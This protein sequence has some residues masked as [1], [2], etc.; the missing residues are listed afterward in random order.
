LLAAAEHSYIGE[1]DPEME[2]ALAAEMIVLGFPTTLACSIAFAMTGF[3]L[4]RL[5]L[6][7]PGPSRTEMFAFWL[8]FLLAGYF[9]WFVAAPWVARSLRKREH[10]L[11]EE[12]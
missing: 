8:I 11:S 1:A 3:L 12:P 6:A 2:E 10:L 5:G 7:L 9:Q 4:E